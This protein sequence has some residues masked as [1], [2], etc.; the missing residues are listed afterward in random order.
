MLTGSFCLDLLVETYHLL[1]F[2]L[3][4]EGVEL[5]VPNVRQEA[6]S[7]Y[8]LEIGGKK[9]TKK[10]CSSLEAE[11]ITEGGDMKLQGMCGQQ[12]LLNISDC[13][14]VGQPAEPSFTRL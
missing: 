3:I 1:C 9:E 7:C 10:L 4:W 2:F 12:Q 11:V 6:L 5:I 14:K 13:H 8:R